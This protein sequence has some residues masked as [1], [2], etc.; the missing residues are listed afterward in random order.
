MIYLAKNAPD[1]I[2][3]LNRKLREQHL[4]NWISTASQSVGV[5]EHGAQAL[6]ILNS[7]RTDPDGGPGR[8]RLGEGGGCERGQGT[9]HAA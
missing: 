9:N 5:F 3:S 2:E 6:A 4:P 1:R 8:R 7:G